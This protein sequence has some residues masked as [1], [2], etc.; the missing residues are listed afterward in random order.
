MIYNVDRKQSGFILMVRQRNQKVYLTSLF[1]MMY[2]VINPEKVMNTHYV[3]NKTKL[4]QKHWLISLVMKTVNSY[5][6]Q[7]LGLVKHYQPMI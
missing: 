6:T 5:G 3:R 2:Q 7:N 4:L 1:I